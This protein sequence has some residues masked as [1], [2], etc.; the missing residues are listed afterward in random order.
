LTWLRSCRSR[1]ASRRGCRSRPHPCGLRRSFPCHFLHFSGCF[2]L[3]FCLRNALNLLANLLGHVDWNGTR[4]RL[5]F[6]DTESGQ[7]VN[8][9]FGLDLQFAGQFVDPD[10]I[11]VAHALRSLLSVL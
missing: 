10:L 11:R 1:S 3:S 6:R 4:V 2:G 5:F 8:D 9:G 7:K